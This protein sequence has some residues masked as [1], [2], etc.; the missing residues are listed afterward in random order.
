[1]GTSAD[2]LDATRREVAANIRK[3]TE[4]AISVVRSP[5]EHSGYDSDSD[6]DASFFCVGEGEKTFEQLDR[7][8]R[9]SGQGTDPWTDG[10]QRA[11]RMC[12]KA[13]PAGVRGLCRE[14]ERR[15][16]RPKTMVIGYDGDGDDERGEVRPPPPPKDEAKPPSLRIVKDTSAPLPTSG[17]LTLTNPPDPF[18]DEHEIPMRADTAT[19]GGIALNSFD[20]RPM[21]T[22]SA[23]QPVIS[24]HADPDDNNAVSPVSPMSPE[25]ATRYASPYERWQTA[26]LRAEYEQFE[27]PC[28]QRPPALQSAK[29]SA[30][31]QLGLLGSFDG[32]YVA[33]Q[34]GRALRTRG[35]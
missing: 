28:P 26:E 31:A 5:F 3:S 30:S 18:R 23:H 20:S 12:R 7:E 13:R 14:C 35:W 25:N 2:V 11:C 19:A 16:R 29:T 17:V 1:M 4:R 8:R 15:F 24:Y 33:V 6:S 9:F 27:T 34:D 21:L 22:A 32:L 10:Q